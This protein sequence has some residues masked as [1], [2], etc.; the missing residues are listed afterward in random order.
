MSLDIQNR[1]HVKLFVGFRL[2]AELRMHLN[3]SASWKQDSVGEP[4]EDSGRLVEVHFQENIY[5]GKFITRD[6]VTVQDLKE[7]ELQTTKQILEYCPNLSQ[8][9]LKFCIF[10]QFFVQ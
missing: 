4:A 5:I 1:V 10:P 3:Q 7:Y 9:A 8:D 6:R 2:T